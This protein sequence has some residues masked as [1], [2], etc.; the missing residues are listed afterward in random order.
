MPFPEI[1]N[2]FLEL[3][4]QKAL[5]LPVVALILGAVAQV[6]GLMELA[7]RVCNPA[8]RRPSPRTT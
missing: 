7:D 3:E 1:E 2:E 4:K 5:S 8:I 6:E